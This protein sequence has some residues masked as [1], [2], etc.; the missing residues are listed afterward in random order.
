MT[1]LCVSKSTNGNYRV[2]VRCME[3]GKVYHHWLNSR[4]AKR[5]EESGFL[6]THELFSYDDLY[7]DGNALINRVY[8]AY[9]YVGKVVS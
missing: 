4:E 2:D 5:L 7:K 8:R 6:A 9:K 1:I 3:D